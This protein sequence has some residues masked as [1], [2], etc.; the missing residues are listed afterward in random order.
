VEGGRYLSGDGQ[1]WGSSLFQRL[2]TLSF[3]G[4]RPGGERKRGGGSS[5]KRIIEERL[6][7][8]IRLEGGGRS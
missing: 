7:S 3:N 5:E 8:L 6:I 4:L 2:E 1:S